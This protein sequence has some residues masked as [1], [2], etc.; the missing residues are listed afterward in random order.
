MEMTTPRLQHYL[1]CLWQ[2][3]NL[4]LSQTTNFRRLQTERVCRR[5][6]AGIFPF[7]HRFQMTNTADT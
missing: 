1:A 7:P 2:K 4:T 3:A 6:M 5:Q